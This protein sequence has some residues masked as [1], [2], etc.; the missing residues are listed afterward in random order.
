M[1]SKLSRACDYRGHTWSRHWYAARLSV[2]ILTTALPCQERAFKASPIVR[3]QEVPWEAGSE[4]E[5]SLLPRRIEEVRRQCLETGEI[6][7][8]VTALVLQ[9][10]KPEFK[11]LTPT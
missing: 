2:T 11:S 5:H 10:C 9:A 8:W 7:Q 1:S 6:A 3:R 4:W